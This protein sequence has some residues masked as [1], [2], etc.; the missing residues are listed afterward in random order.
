[1]LHPRSR[2]SVSDPANSSLPSPGWRD[3]FRWPEFTVSAPSRPAVHRALRLVI[4]AGTAAAGVCL[5]L[6]MTV[7]VIQLGATRVTRTASSRPTVVSQSGN[8]TASL[9]GPG[10]TASD[11]TAGHWIAGPAIASF[12]STGAARN[13]Q[14]AVSSP[15]TWGL[16]WT[17]SCP[18]R[19]SGTF[20]LTAKGTTTGDDVELDVAGPTGRGITW[21]TRDAG[22]HSLDVS[23]DCSWTARVVLPKTPGRR[24]ASS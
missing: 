5:V 19:R 23:S 18:A 20:Q 10:P 1:M 11:G 7:L 8:S 16:S 24:P 3:S 13:D 14:F 12:N 15:G 4:A 21:N 2:S 17:F 9:G 22:D 6:A